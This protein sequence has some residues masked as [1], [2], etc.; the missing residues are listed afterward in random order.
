MDHMEIGQPTIPLKTIFKSVGIIVSAL[1]NLKI[2]SGFQQRNST[3][4]NISW[5][6]SSLGSRLGRAD[7]LLSLGLF[8]FSVARLPLYTYGSTCLGP[9]GSN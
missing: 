6:R 4:K 5:W 8:R 3:F 9:P 2:D 1:G 7:N